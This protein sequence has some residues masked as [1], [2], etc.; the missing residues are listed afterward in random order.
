MPDYTPD[1]LDLKTHEESLRAVIEALRAEPTPGR[2]FLDRV[3]RRHPKG[4]SELFSKAEIIHAF[5]RLAPRYGWQ[6]EEAVFLD[7][8]RMKPVR[9]LSGVT[10]VTVLTKPFPCPG[11]CVFCPSDVRMP[12]SYLSMEPGAQRATTNAFDPYRQTHNRLRAFYN[13]GHR[14]DKVELI[15]LG[16]TWSSY[17]ESYQIWFLTRCFEALNEFSGGGEPANGSS[18]GLDFLDLQE[19]LDGRKLT[20]SYNE[21]V[22]GHLKSRLGGQLQADDEHE[23]LP[24]LHEVQRANES[25]DSRCVGLSLETRPDH[26]D[27]AQVEWLRGLGATKIQLGY[28][29]LS[30]E[31]LRLNQ[32][33]HDVETSRVATHRLRAA[34]FKVQAHWMPNLYGSDP[35]ADIQDFEQ[36]FGDP[37]FRPDELKIYPCSLLAS[38]ELRIHHEAGRWRPY[39]EAE[40]V[41]VLGACLSRVPEYCRVTRVIRDIPSHDILVGS[42]ATNLRQRVEAL[43]EARNIPVRDIRSRQVRNLDCSVDELTLREM[44]YETSVGA[45]VFLQFV[46][47]KDRLVGFLR[48]TLPRTATAMEELNGSALVREVHVYGAVTAIGEREVGRSQH[49]GLG[50]RL[51]DRAAEIAQSNGFRGSRPRWLALPSTCTTASCSCRSM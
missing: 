1:G 33:G 11:K 26:V 41:E 46:T 16:G 21:V 22:S 19:T 32:R 35:R 45:E 42:G 9:T 39:T 7:K 29:S 10:P 8:I 36:M 27:L 14:L 23:S 5:R 25:A 3:V 2:D 30:D 31:V 37:D 17:P 15:V 50:S 20:R 49:R 34:G 24:R 28:Q 6:D 47:P 40:L 38:A 48:L 13:N 4:R 51:L 43:L 12:K 44:R 18:A